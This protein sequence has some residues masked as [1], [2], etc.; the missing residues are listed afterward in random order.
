MQYS[1]DIRD[2]QNNALRAVVGQSPTL[3]I[4]DG[5]MPIDCNALDSGAL[6]AVGTLPATWLSPSV[7]GV[8][9]LGAEWR[10]LGQIGAGAGKRPTYFRIKSDGVCRIQ[11][12]FGKGMDM[13][14]EDDGLIANGQMVK[15]LAFSITRGNA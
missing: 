7:D 5:D 6:L 15:V 11:G 1:T 12:T 4:R 14:T 3:E 13:Q 2:A 10:I 8:T 9:A